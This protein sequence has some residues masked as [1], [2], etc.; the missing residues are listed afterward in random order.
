MAVVACQCSNPTSLCST[1]IHTRG[2]ILPPDWLRRIGEL[3]VRGR[4][5]S[6]QWQYKM[7]QHKESVKRVI[8]LHDQWRRMKREKP[9]AEPQD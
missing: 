5:D 9:Q 2:Y 4:E 1:C 7:M 6:T 3:P 8:R